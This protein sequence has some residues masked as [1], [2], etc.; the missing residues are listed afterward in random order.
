MAITLSIASLIKI[1]PIVSGTP[2]TASA[3]TLTDHNRE[4]VQIAEE[5]IEQSARMANGTMRKYIVATKK[6]FSTTWSDLPNS[7]SATADGKSGL[8]E[9]NTFYNNFFQ[10]PIKLDLIYG[11]GTPSASYNVFIKDFTR[12]IK[13]RSTAGYD[14]WDVSL[15]WD[16]I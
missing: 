7:G 5:K 4:P 11:S 12:S 2:L 16:E 9:M 10:Y 15:S 8:N 6:S 3:I 13:K 1:T 14:M